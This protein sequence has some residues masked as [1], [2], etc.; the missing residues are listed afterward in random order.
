M[1]NKL[2]AFSLGVL[3]NTL[4]LIVLILFLLVII[5]AIFNTRPL[6]GLQLAYTPN[7][8]VYK[9]ETE[10]SNIGPDM[11]PTID[12]GTATLFVS[13]LVYK[14]KVGDI[15]VFE[16]KGSKC[17]DNQNKKIVRRYISYSKDGCMNLTA[18]NKDTAI[19]TNDYACLMPDDIR[20]LGTLWVNTIPKI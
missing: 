10:T 14:P 1:Q 13:H 17:G 3:R 15:L 8:I 12:I 9:V 19:N 11:M 2:K 7:L 18:D 4:F 20:I 16:C 6:L 5:P